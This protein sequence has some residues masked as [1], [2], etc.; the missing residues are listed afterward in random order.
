MCAYNIYHVVWSRPQM[1]DILGVCIP[2]SKGLFQRTGRMLSL[3]LQGDW[4]QFR[5]VQKW[6]GRR[7]LWFTWVT[8]G[9]WGNSDQSELQNRKEWIG[10]LVSQ[11][12]L[13]VSRTALFRANSRYA[14]SHSVM[15]A[16]ELKWHIMLTSIKEVKVITGQISGTRTPH[17]EY[18]AW[19]SQEYW[20]FINWITT[21][22]FVARPL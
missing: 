12:E 15:W 18:Y 8:Q 21:R 19:W 20:V 2:C 7:S 9:V 22:T 17:K 6:S 1:M 16:S 3:H 13:R 10:L 14:V 11:W 4:I 5:W